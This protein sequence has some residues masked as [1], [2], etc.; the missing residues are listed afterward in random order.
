MPDRIT[1]P[2]F[3]RRVFNLHWFEGMDPEQHE[4]ERF[5]QE[6][7]AKR[8]STEDRQGYAAFWEEWR[9]RRANAT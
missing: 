8:P 1:A 2:P 3:A 6:S 4:M 7:A 5:Y 9:A